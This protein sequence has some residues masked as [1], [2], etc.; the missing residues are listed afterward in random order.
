LCVLRR[1]RGVLKTGLYVFEGAAD[2]ALC[3]Q[4][5]L[6]APVDTCAGTV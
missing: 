6:F 5:C 3:G 2:G 4:P 1:T